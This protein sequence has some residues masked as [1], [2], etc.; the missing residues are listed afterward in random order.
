MPS[1][2]CSELASP[3]TTTTCL[4]VSKLGSTFASSGTSVPSTSTTWSSAWF[5]TKVSCSGNSR[6]LRVCSTAPIAGT[7]R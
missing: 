6:M 2:A 5:A 3:F 4:T 7:A 1:G